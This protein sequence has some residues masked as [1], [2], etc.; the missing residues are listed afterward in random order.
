MRDAGIPK[1]IGYPAELPHA[2]S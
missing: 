1:T 2:V